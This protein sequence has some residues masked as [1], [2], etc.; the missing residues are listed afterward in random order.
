MLAD[1]LFTRFPRPNFCLALHD[2]AEQA[3][4][5]IGAPSGYSHANVDSVDILVKG[6]GGHGAWPNKT[7]DPIVLASQIVLALQTIVSRET[8]PTDPAVVTVGTFHGGTK[9]NI[10]PDEVKLQLTVRTYSDEVRKTT[11][12][13][14]RRI[15]RGEAI[16]AGVPEDRMPEVTLT[17]ESTAALY[18]DP[19]L[20]ERLIQTWRRCFG[21]DRV[22]PRKSAMGGEDFAEFGRTK[23]KIPLCMFAVGAVDP[24]VIKLSEETGRPLPSL[25]SSKWAPVVEPTIKTGTEA[26][27]TALLELMPR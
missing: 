26:M 25:H 9:R 7:K 23:D 16:A 15:V 2:S 27:C 17:E 24:K 4:G 20:S 5:T 21:V 14:I 1:G 11:I 18:N 3:A 22:A 8:A 6:V 13:S 10:I 12:E 19:E